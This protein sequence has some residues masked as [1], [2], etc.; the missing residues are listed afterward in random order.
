V[1]YHACAGEAPPPH[2]IYVEQAKGPLPRSAL[3]FWIEG[4]WVEM[5]SP[6]P[7]PVVES[8]V[9]AAAPEPAAESPLPAEPGAASTPLVA[10]E[11]PDA[12]DDDPKLDLPIYRWLGTEDADGTAGAAAPG[13]PRSLLSR[14]DATG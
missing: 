11:V 10:A 6:E 13:W 5:A 1:D 4:Q 12:P 9:T 2:A 8:L 14:R 7:E 3:R